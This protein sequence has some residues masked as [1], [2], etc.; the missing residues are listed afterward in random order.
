MK[1]KNKL[2]KLFG[3]GVLSACLLGGGLY[4]ANKNDSP[5]MEKT[6]N[7]YNSISNSTP[8]FFKTTNISNT[9][10]FVDIV[11]DE[12]ANLS[13]DVA[14]EENGTSLIGTH[15][16]GNAY[17]AFDITNITISLN[18]TTVSGIDYSSA[19]KSF[20]SLRTE[21]EKTTDTTII[22]GKKYYI[23]TAPET[24]TEV[25]TPVAGDI[26]SYYEEIEI[27]DYLYGLNFYQDSLDLDL[28]VDLEADN[29]SIEDGKLTLNEQG[30]VSVK[31]TYTKYDLSLAPDKTPPELM[32]E[33]VSPNETI[34]YNF[35]LLDRHSYLEKGTT[36]SPSITY[37]EDTTNRTA[38]AS[39]YKYNYFYNYNFDSVP[40]ISYDPTLYEVTVIKVGSNNSSRTNRIQYDYS[41]KQFSV[42]DST[43][44]LV[45]NAEISP[46]LREENNKT[47]LDIYF[48]NIGEYI[49]Q[50]E[51]ICISN[52]TY[53]T[54][55]T[56]IKSQRF[57]VFGYQAFYTVASAKYEELKTYD[58]PSA[59]SNSAD[60]TD[61]FNRTDKPLTIDDAD[62]DN[63]LNA[64]IAEL[65]A[66]TDP[67]DNPISIAL[68]STDQTPVKLQSI[69]GVT[70]NSSSKV[71]YS[72]NGT[73][74][75]PRDFSSVEDYSL[76]GKYIIAINYN[77][78][79]YTNK[80]GNINSTQEFSQYFAFEISKSTPTET[81][82]VFNINNESGVEENIS[83]FAYTNDKVYIRYDS[84]ANIYFKPVR[85]E[86][87]RYDFNKKETSSE[88]INWYESGENYILDKDGTIAV[89]Q[90]GN[91][92]I[93]IYLYE[94]T[95][96][97]ERHFNI[98][99]DKEFHL[100]SYTVEKD[101]ASQNSFVSD[102][103][104]LLTNQSIVF[105]WDNV[106][107]SGATTSGYWKHYPIST[108]QLY[109]SEGRF[110][111]EYITA[112]INKNVLPVDYELNLSANASWLQYD[113][114]NYDL[115]SNKPINS[116]FIKSNAG[117]HI[118]QTQDIA[119]NTQ[120]KIFIVDYST[121]VFLS[122]N[123]NTT[124]YELLSQ[125]NTLTEDATII[126]GDY[127]VIKI[128]KLADGSYVLEDLNSNLF[129]NRENKYDP[130]IYKAFNDLLCGED[131]TNAN[132]NAN[133]SFLSLPNKTSV[134][135]SYYLCVKI[136]DDVFFKDAYTDTEY[137]FISGSEYDYSYDIVS[138]YK[139]YQFKDSGKLYRSTTQGT[140]AYLSIEYKSEYPEYNLDASNL[141]E[142]KTYIYNRSNYLFSYEVNGITRYRLFDIKTNMIGDF[143][144]VTSDETNLYYNGSALTPVEFV[145]KEGQYV[146][147][148]RDQSN[149]KGRNYNAAEQYRSYPS[150][151]QYVDITGDQ[152]RLTTY[153]IDENGRE[154]TLADSSYFIIES[155][156]IDTGTIN[157]DYITKK[158]SYFSPTDENVIYISFIPTTE[159]GDKMIQVET[160]KVTYYEF[161]TEVYNTVAGVASDYPNATVYNYYKTLSLSSEDVV[162]YEYEE[163]ITQTERFVYEL[164]ITE[165][166]T[167]AGFY[168]ITRTYM[169]NENKSESDQTDYLV[170]TYDY[171]ERKHNAYVD[172]YDVITQSESIS[173][174]ATEHAVKITEKDPVT[175]TQQEYLF[176]VLSVPSDLNGDPS[177]NYLS[178]YL[179]IPYTDD[180]IYATG[181]NATGEK[182]TLDVSSLVEFEFKLE[183]QYSYVN[184]SW[185]DLLSGARNIFTDSNGQTYILLDF[186]GENGLTFGSRTCYGF[187][188]FRSTNK[189]VASG[190]NYSMEVQDNNDITTRSNQSL[191]GGS[192]QVTMY[193]TYSKSTVLSIAHPSQTNN[194]IMLF[195]SGDSFYT[196]A[197]TS[198]IANLTSRLGSGTN[199]LPVSIA[200]PK[201]K[202]TTYFVKT[203][204]T[205][206]LNSNNNVVCN[207]VYETDVLS[208]FNQN[209]KDSGISSYELDVEV[210]YY[211]NGV[212]ENTPPTK[213]YKSNGTIL[214]NIY[215]S[216]NYS[217]SESSGY[218]ALYEYNHQTGVYGALHNEF[219]DAG[220]YIVRITQAPYEIASS[221]YNFKS[222]YSFR[223]DIERNSPEFEV[224]SGMLLKS[225][226]DSGFYDDYSSLETEENK[227]YY[228]NK[229]EISVKWTDSS[230]V[231]KANIDKTEIQI[232]ITGSRGLYNGTFK[233][234]LTEP[235]TGETNGIVS[236]SMFNGSS[237]MDVPSLSSYFTYTYSASTLTNTI[238]FNLKDLQMNINNAQV[239]I[240]MQLVGHNPAYYKTTSK[241]IVFDKTASNN[242]VANLHSFLYSQNYGLSQEEI[243][244]YYEAD[245]T[246]VTDVSNASYNQTISSGVYAGYAFTVARDF[247]EGLKA[248]IKSNIDSGFHSLTTAVY[249]KPIDDSYTPTS[250]RYSFVAND[251]T[252][253]TN[254][255]VFDENAIL[256][257]KS[258][259]IVE[260]DLAGNLTI[261]VVYVTAVDKTYTYVDE[262]FD[263]YE[264]DNGVTFKINGKSKATS[265]SDSEMSSNKYDISSSTGFAVKKINHLG[266]DWNYFYT[267]IYNSS[268]GTY[269]N[270]YYLITPEIED[271]YAYKITGVSTKTY[272]KFALA[273]LF[274]SAEGTYKSYLS[275]LNKLTGTYSNVAISLSDSARLSYATGEYGTDATRSAYL[276]IAL[277][278]Y[279]LTN[280]ELI[281][282]KP[283]EIEIIDKSNDTENCIFGEVEAEGEVSDVSD[284]GRNNPNDHVNEETYDYLATWLAKSNEY[285]TV[286]YANNYLTFTI[287]S[288]RS[289][290]KLAFRVVDNFG[291]EINEIYL[292]GETKVDEITS[293]G[294][295]YS[296]FTEVDG[297]VNNAY[298]SS[299]E[300]NTN[301]NKEKYH[302]AIYLISQ[303]TSGTELKEVPTGYL[304]SENFANKSTLPFYI[305]PSSKGSVG[306]YTFGSVQNQYDIWLRVEYYD[307]EDVVEGFTPNV[308]EAI[309]VYYIR[310][311]NM[312]PN[313]GDDDGTEND[314]YFAFTNSNG[315]DDT[316]EL[317][318]PL[319]N[320]NGIETFTLNGKTYVL[321][322]DQQTF[323]DEL[324]VAYSSSAN[325]DIPYEVLYYS[326]AEGW[327]NGEDFVPLASGSVLNTNGLY[328]ILV[329]Y[330]HNSVLTNEYYLFKIEILGSDGGYYYILANGER[331]EAAPTYY[332]YN[333]TQYSNYYI[334]NISSGDRGLEEKF[335]IVTNDYQ[336]VKE[337]EFPVPIFEATG[338]NTYRYVITNYLDMLG[339]APTNATE[340]DAANVAP[341]ENGV[342]PFKQY[343][344]VTFLSPPENNDLL[345]IT[346]Q[347]S[348]SNLYYKTDDTNDLYVTSS[349]SQITMIIYDETADTDSMTLSWFKY[350]G[351]QSNLIN[352]YLEKDGKKVS[353]TT[354]ES[355]NYYYINLTR[356]GLYSLRFEDVAGN[357]QSFYSGQ[358]SLPLV[359]IKDVH[360]TTSYT[361]PLTGEVEETEAVNKAVYNSAV[362]LKLNQ[363]LI[364]YYQASGFGSG[365]IITV[366][367][368]GK[369]YEQE[370]ADKKGY[371][372]SSDD[373]S[374]TF[375]EAG[376]YTV[377]MDANSKSTGD[378]IR[379][380]VYTFSIINA[381][382]SRYAFEF[383]GYKDYY[384]ESVIKDGIDITDSL[385]ALL[386]TNTNVTTLNVIENDKVVAKNYLKNLLVSYFDEKTG[387]GR[388]QI[389][390]NSN[391]ELY[392]DD[393]EG[394]STF[395]FEFFINSQAVPISVSIE[396]GGSTT[397]NVNVDFN[398]KNVY[399]AVGECYIVV[400]NEIFYVDETT[401]DTMTLVL[402]DNERSNQIYY[403]QVFTMSGNLLFSHRVNL[404]EPMNAWTIIAII[405]GAIAVVLVVFIIV[406][407]RKRMGVK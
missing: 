234:S 7:A 45:N 187:S 159:F 150:A 233:L 22:T 317:L 145:D 55:D 251:F 105:S 236:V 26:D 162:I 311:Y 49:L 169:T 249:Y 347:G 382:E 389:T 407:L 198:N 222:T 342:S 245:G 253:I 155:E 163:G 313:K 375:E 152:S 148:L 86:L 369:I 193:S 219:T 273:D 156:E 394:T 66:T 78:A 332:T 5:V 214:D 111:K 379:N 324:K 50:Y 303:K 334:V 43:N 160:V 228:T 262:S 344:F 247:F 364:P 114:F 44:T 98:D 267:S 131:L 205:S 179:Y 186:S 309:K 208:Y 165:E 358:K 383:S 146:F 10:S 365:N 293:N 123:P 397:D 330:S 120:T 351:I 199:K 217:I 295:I 392:I 362:T 381:K 326:T 23:Q 96:P 36:D 231:Y 65:T 299:Q 322:S 283:V 215:K 117:L 39:P 320:I 340:A 37:N 331:K 291:N 335:E 137:K 226:S 385:Y 122:Y 161:K 395:T 274:K 354:H 110:L 271:G 173:P 304:D 403:I 197:D 400:G 286:T 139:L 94:S 406:K 338:I 232:T 25:S 175:G 246:T 346:T 73:T 35:F 259:E 224:Y 337:F 289:D 12:W 196:K 28:S 189:T 355:G 327:N 171:N 51:P 84:F 316:A 17:N 60:I 74:W 248:D 166:K 209:D 360:F 178:K 181:T 116:S 227:I 212:L 328:Y 63:S 285:V 177:A 349:T 8:A 341:K 269:L 350:Y 287:Q 399:D 170:T 292:V 305:T 281:Q 134:Q 172:R 386:K 3:I 34:T 370:K 255:S 343:V 129:K 95:N 83:D 121:P 308:N 185:S 24:Y 243:R 203:V 11:S 254:S 336:N 244:E 29:N 154:I 16:N 75:T 41:T 112:F 38:S 124:L 264:L 194:S 76:P 192:M 250:N 339:N 77:F 380:E 372:F 20:Y 109:D 256:L 211:E 221:S 53:Y 357:V 72:S 133:I 119:G 99:T 353:V 405:A 184:L 153:F 348:T 294:N 229:N 239:T 19:I 323:S 252:Q 377:S 188:K 93:N 113:N 115:N 195:N 307:T 32:Q 297:N 101:P 62:L 144:N 138:S 242:T 85:F 278:S 126:W 97:I 127:K 240:R 300:I 374:F 207:Y 92:T 68:A 47:I 132:E 87:I 268:L 384:I 27:K 18:G 69:E 279:V 265:I 14:E 46:V 89:E 80:S 9:Y 176:K 206:A 82:N 266:D 104:E 404:T 174:R 288:V 200:I 42:Y 401:V 276:S 30:L 280:N 81:L 13:F 230:S 210:Q 100:K 306:S 277:P 125:N 367:K 52:G 270:S 282:A 223:F 312:L 107:K 257:N 57:Y 261:Y 356:S 388:Y 61:R 140:G 314:Y 368:D 373:F 59:Y 329:R 296:Y 71:Y 15:F 363:L 345:S 190:L 378:K 302:V 241:T 235:A 220:C 371:I 218:L 325:L 103:I 225:I 88:Y 213:V 147:L 157:A 201:Y 359:F 258:Y 263:S 33:N 390:I 191:V 64:I 40:N 90:D 318:T 118:F 238:S 168:E 91:Y 108:K 393:N 387:G 141:I 135:S 79:S 366:Y 183:G 58:S 204:H 1:M 321:Y 361:N 290:T 237:W 167:K 319:T 402:G 182:V 333:G 202:Y 396:D 54:I 376:Y 315:G 391:D 158:S 106:K 70:A 352:V 56:E 298:I 284:L 48:N 21:Y 130:Y 164:N 6:A 136:N 67:E 143:V 310:L 180:K 31:I 2:S 142:L 128:P 272:T 151:Y 102:E 275:V 149:T 216:G 398:A 301:Y 4:I 260:R